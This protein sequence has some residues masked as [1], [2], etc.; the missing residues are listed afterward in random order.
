MKW[1]TLLPAALLVALWVPL[2][3]LADE[4]A[5]LL[6][7]RIQHARLDPAGD[8]WNAYA[9]TLQHNVAPHVIN[10]EIEYAHRYA[11]QDTRLSAS[12]AWRKASLN[13][14]AGASLSAQ[15][16]LFP[17][18]SG[19]LGVEKIGTRAV[20]RLIT[21]VD[22]YDAYNITRISLGQE[23]YWRAFLLSGTVYYAQQAS[24]HATVIQPALHYFIDDHT[25]WKLFIASGH[26]FEV[27]S[28]QQA[29]DRTLTLLGTEI[30]WKT[31]EG[32]GFNLSTVNNN[33]S[34]G[35]DRLEMQLGYTHKF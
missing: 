17:N 21:A 33:Y 32:G 6:G 9:I 1:R 15:R 2:R 16:T 14:L 4:S 3:S 18:Y 7:A 12:A 5:W 10:T 13:W 20:S 29:I 25:Q 28:D 11:L 22:H 23:Y 30:R 31:T 26:E 35:N 27:V 8:P 19:Y 24:H 34:R